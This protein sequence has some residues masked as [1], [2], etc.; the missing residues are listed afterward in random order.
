MRGRLLAAAIAWTV[1]SGAASADECKAYW[2][3]V[4]V[5]RILAMEA[6]PGPNAL[7]G[8]G[9]DAL[10][11]VGMSYP[12]NAEQV[13]AGQTYRCEVI[14]RD[15]RPGKAKLFCETVIAKDDF[16]A[17]RDKLQGCLAPFGYEM[18][19]TSEPHWET[20]AFVN[21]ANESLQIGF[22]P[23]NGGVYLT[24]EQ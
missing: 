19:V 2:N 24:A 10:F 4:W 14:V 13:W 7:L 18:T 6:V 9:A 22:D 1:A 20:V 12:V 8:Q 21:K 15:D 3:D 16:D 17:F 11:D 5:L 23:Y